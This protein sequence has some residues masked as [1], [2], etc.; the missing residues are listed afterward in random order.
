VWWFHALTITTV[1]LQLINF[2]IL[3]QGKLKTS[4]YLLLVIYISLI[5]V[6]LT[7]AFRDTAGQWSVGLY[8]LV[9]AWAIAMAI[10]G[11]RRINKTEAARS[12]PN[13]SRNP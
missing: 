6:E 7:I 4:Y 12:H 3:S 1:V 5:V 2:W 13:T 8:V 11:I 10:V 9:D